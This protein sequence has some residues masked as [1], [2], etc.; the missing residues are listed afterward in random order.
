[1]SRL[2]LSA[3]GYIALLGLAANPASTPSEDEWPAYGRDPGGQRFSPLRQIHRE[4][5]SSLRVAW[6]FRTGDA[7]QPKHSRPTAFEATPIYIDGTL[8]LATPLGRVI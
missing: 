5:V 2:G 8:F 6:T 7:Y 4:N 1:M 3:I